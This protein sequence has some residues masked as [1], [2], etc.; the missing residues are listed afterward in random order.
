MLRNQT[1]NTIGRWRKSYG[2]WCVNFMFQ[3]YVK[4]YFPLLRVTSEERITS[5]PPDFETTAPADQDDW[6][7]LCAYRRQ[8]ACHN[9]PK[10]L[11]LS[12]T[13][14]GSRADTPCWLARLTPLSVPYL[15]RGSE[16]CR[17]ARAENPAG[18]VGR[19]LV[20]I[21]SGEINRAAIIRERRGPDRPRR[22]QRLTRCGRT[23]DLSQLVAPA[24]ISG[25]KPRTSVEPAIT[26][27]D[28]AMAA[29][30]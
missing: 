13:A 4:R 7:A 26:D 11:P 22:H 1:A 30:N 9:R 6:L 24:R 18:I 21:V 17:Q 8:S 12:R 14:L 19:C 20:G 23:S 2:N 28:N 16:C 29:R 3:A 15:V 10:A 5:T 25:Q 27:I